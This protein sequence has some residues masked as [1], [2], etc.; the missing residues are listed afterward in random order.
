[1][2][3]TVRP[4]PVPCTCRSGFRPVRPS[5]KRKK[6]RQVPGLH[7]QDGPNRHSA[8]IPAVLRPPTAAATPGIKTPGSIS[9]TGTAECT[10]NG[11]VSQRIRGT[12]GG[13]GRRGLGSWGVGE[14]GGGGTPVGR[15]GCA[16]RSER[17][18]EEAPGAGTEY[19]GR[20]PHYR[21]V[22]FV[23]GGIC[24]GEG[25]GGGGGRIRGRT[26]VPR[27]RGADGVVRHADA[28]VKGRLVPRAGPEKAGRDRCER[29]PGVDG[30]NRGAVE[31]PQKPGR[32][33]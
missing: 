18:Y 20:V 29:I 17:R 4:V 25:G 15:G 33:G 1:M 6:R 30:D 8:G 16:G 32:A 12:G 22:P 3:R 2:S 19:P 10:Q 27:P 11:C 28:A 14:G 7:R 5:R 21:D 26:G 31:M 13:G 9:N 24:Y 23:A